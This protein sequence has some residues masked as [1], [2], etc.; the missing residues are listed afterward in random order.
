MRMIPKNK[1]MIKFEMNNKNK[2]S[3]AFTTAS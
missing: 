2:M 3:T 1:K